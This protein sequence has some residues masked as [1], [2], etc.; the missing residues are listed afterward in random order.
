[1]RQVLATLAEI[2]RGGTMV[3]LAEQN[4]YAALEIAHRGYVLESGRIV[5]EGAAEQLMAHADV[6]RAYIGA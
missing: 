3:L 2:N 6:K 1:V 4:A 5:L